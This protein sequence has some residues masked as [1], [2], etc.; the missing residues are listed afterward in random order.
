[1]HAFHVAAAVTLAACGSAQTDRVYRLADL[2]VREWTLGLPVSGDGTLTVRIEPPQPSEWT[3][4][5][6]QVDFACDGC[7]LGDDQTKL[8][9]RRFGEF[10][11]EP[12]RF[13]RLELGTVRA[14]VVFGDGQMK[15]TSRWR[16][17]ELVLDAEVRGTLAPRAK[18]IAID[19]CVVFHAT[20]ALEQRDPVM[21]AMVETTGA[22]RNASGD[23]TIKLEGTVGAIKRLGKECSLTGD[24]P[25]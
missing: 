25:Q 4:V 8:D 3:A 12:A 23:F 7:T 9:L 15:M 10:F 18:D 19:G 14:H 5:H 20:R 16:S 17:R 24:G 11:G 21:F 2:P 6:G 13:G 1:M 22:P